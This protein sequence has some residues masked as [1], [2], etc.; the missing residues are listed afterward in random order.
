MN[1]IY[2]VKVNYV[3]MESG[4]VFEK[5][6]HFASDFSAKFIAKN[7]AKCEDVVSVEVMDTMTGEIIYYHY[8]DGD[9]YEAG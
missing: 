3:N 7:Y 5:K 4:T 9:E 8:A 6:I 1:T 2:E